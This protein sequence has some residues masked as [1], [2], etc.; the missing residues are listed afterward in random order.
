[1]RNST[2]VKAGQIEEI[3]SGSPE[4]YLPLYEFTFTNINS[5]LNEKIAKS[6]HKLHGISN[7][8]FMEVIYE[9]LRDMFTYKAKSWML[10]NR[11]RRHTLHPSSL[12]T[13]LMGLIGF[14]LVS[15]NSMPL[16]F[17]MPSLPRIKRSL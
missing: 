7:R 2:R 4:A 8:R 3:I 11:P 1:M 15:G 10:S 6:R 9:I 13:S 12:L 5:K 17:L 16:R 14:A